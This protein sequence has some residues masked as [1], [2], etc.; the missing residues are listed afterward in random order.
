M[1]T[2]IFNVLIPFFRSDEFVERFLDLLFQ[3]LIGGF[4]VCGL[5]DSCLF[6]GAFGLIVNDQIK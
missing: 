1:P 6:F 2:T 5:H 3:T 4:L